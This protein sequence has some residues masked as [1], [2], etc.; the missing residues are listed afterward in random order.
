MPTAQASFQ[1]TFGVEF[2]LFTCADLIYE[3]PAVALAE[4]RQLLNFVA[5]VSHC[6]CHVFPHLCG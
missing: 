6:L 1:T 5:P 3:F 4:D 2:G